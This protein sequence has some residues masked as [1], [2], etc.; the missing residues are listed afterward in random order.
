MI[1]H[2]EWLNKES[3]L[4]QAD[5][6]EPI[7]VLRANDEL[8]ADTVRGWAGRYL[9]SKGGPD[10]CSKAQYAKYI[11]ALRLASEMEVWSKS[12]SK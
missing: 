5:W 3:C 12:K 1:K 4:N 6:Q 7:F 2:A 10:K 9:M 11:E 8:A